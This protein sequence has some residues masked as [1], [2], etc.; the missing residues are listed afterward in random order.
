LFASFIEILLQLLQVGHVLLLLFV[1]TILPHLL[2]LLLSKSESLSALLFIRFLFLRIHNF[3]EDADV[4][5]PMLLVNAIIE[6]LI[7]VL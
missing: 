3:S 4:V 6:V 2:W 1:L 7:V 5:L